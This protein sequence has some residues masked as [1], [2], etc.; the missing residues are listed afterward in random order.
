[1]RLLL[2]GHDVALWDDLESALA[3]ACH[4]A[5]WVVDAAAADA[6]LGVQDYGAVLLQIRHLDRTPTGLAALRILRE[7]HC[8]VPLIGVVIGG[9]VRER[10]QVLDNG[11][12]DCVA[13]PVSVVE[14]CARLRALRRRLAGRKDPLLS[15]GPL[16]LDTNG[17]T[18]R[19]AGR[20]VDLS[21]KEFALLQVLMENP[22]RV[23]S[24][25]QLEG[26]LYCWRDELGSNAIEVHVHHLRKKLGARMIRTVRGV[27]Y[28]LEPPR[29][30]EPSC[31]GAEAR[32][33]SL[34]GPVRG[35]APG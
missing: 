35:A 9:G 21:R 19:L 1:M 11:A 14:L 33:G 28:V 8:D 15:H 27:G 6:A 22:G 20:P 26:A 3:S 34:R 29:A 12:D 31:P 18:V 32:S 16:V 13:H 10:V 2:V 23:L 4:V 25:R 24:R 30:P 7:R 5:D 17:H